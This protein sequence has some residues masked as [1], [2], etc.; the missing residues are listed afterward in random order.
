MAL[1]LSLYTK[2]G[3]RAKR[4]QWLL[5]EI[6]IEWRTIAGEEAVLRIETMHSS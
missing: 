2:V 6:K 1:S 4:L 5:K 3:G